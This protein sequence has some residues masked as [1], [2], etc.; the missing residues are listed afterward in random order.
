MRRNSLVD[1]RESDFNLLLNSLHEGVCYLNA[2]GE[3]LYF[4][5][6]AQAHWHS[7]HLHS[8]KFSTRSPIARAL[9][10]EYVYH[11]TIH[12]YDDLTLLVSTVPLFNAANT[13]TGAIVISQD[14]S[15]HI[16]LEQETRTAL[17]IFTT[18][19]LE[20]IQ[21]DDGDE[22]LQLSLIHI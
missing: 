11:D 20:T 21:L 10:G 13:V 7:N 5:Q 19:T 15:E 17:D 18:A 3:V 16:I 6:I 8:K 9:V 22:V 12:V 4:N 14:I 1:F 2:Q